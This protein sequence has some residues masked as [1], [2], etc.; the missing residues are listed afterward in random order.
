VNSGTLLHILMALHTLIA[1]ATTFALVYLCYA[2]LK[3][4]RPAADRILLFALTWPLANLI[5]MALNGM[6]CPLQNAAQA[7]SGEPGGWVR[8][9][10]WIPESWLRIIPY[11]FGPSYALG[12][13]LVWW[14]GRP[15]TRP[16][17]SKSAP[18]RRQA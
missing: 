14:R 8:D 1:A 3:R 5:L 7:L 12:A 15:W 16:I 10:Y 11:T 13:A 6:V 9:L 18:P 17:F 2:A 4:R